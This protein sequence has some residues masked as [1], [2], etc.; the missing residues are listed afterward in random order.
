MNSWQLKIALSE[1]RKIGGQKITK[2]M[3]LSVVTFCSK[4]ARDADSSRSAVTCVDGLGAPK[5]SN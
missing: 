4:I 5:R 2:P 1:V 3:V